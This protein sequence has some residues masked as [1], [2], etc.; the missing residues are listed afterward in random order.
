METQLKCCNQQKS[1][2]LEN[3]DDTFFLNHPQIIGLTGD[4]PKRG[5]YM[6][7]DDFRV[8]ILATRDNEGNFRAFLNGCRH[9]G[10]RVA[11]EPRGEAAKFMCPFH[12]WTYS[13]SGDLIAIPRPHDFGPLDKS[14]HGLKELPAEEK[15]GLLWVHP[16]PEGLFDVDELLG[17]LAPELAG[18]NYGDLVYVGESVMRNNLNWKLCNDT[19]GETYHFPR[20]HKNTLGKIFHGD[21]LHYTIF[22]RNH[23][24]VWA[25][26]G[27]DN[28]GNL[29]EEEWDYENVTGML[30]FLFPNV[31]LTG[32]DHSCSLI[33]IYPDGDNPGKSIT[34]VHHYFSQE[35]IDHSRQAERVIGKEDAYSFEARQGDV[36]AS[37]EATMEIFD[38]TI[39]KEDY[40]M[41]ETTQKS[42]ESGLLD[43]VIF[44]R[45]EPALHHY[46]NTFRAA[47]G[48]EP[49]EVFG[50]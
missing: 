6:T 22:N 26:K 50:A 16:Q 47:L 2:S 28:I 19:F 7:I 3:L 34:R 14:C 18:W 4:L 17:D 13:N 40:L 29:P 35:M 15:H 49:M 25:T 11:N 21:A 37:I 33:K 32:G 42:A 9:R 39:E 44:G 46:H 12:N 5:S 31:Q 38:S 30:Y 10:V 20:L 23:R 24:F 27:I 1:K 48:M 8:P 43:H 36:G 41:G 45:N